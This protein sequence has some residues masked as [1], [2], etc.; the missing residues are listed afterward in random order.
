MRNDS[1]KRFKKY[2]CEANLEIVKH[3]LVIH[4]WGNVSGRE[5]ETGYIVIKPS[6]VSYNRMK[7]SDMVVLDIFGNIIEG[8]WKPSTDT[9]T[10]LLLYKSW[11]SVGGIVHTHSTYATA[12]SQAGRG[13]PALGTTHADCFYGEVP[14]TR[15]LTTSEIKNDYEANTGRVIIERLMKN[16]PFNMPA[17]LVN[18]HGPFVWGKDADEAVYNAVTLEE[19]AKIAFYTMLIGKSEPIEQELLDKHF[20]RKHGTDSYYG[21]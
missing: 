1:I 19:V 2:I 17:V 20:F 3:G 12:W 7:E 10:H 11:P 21:Q 4:S 5:P 8:K 15:E 6:G 16:D 18:N 9:P 13:I 14:C